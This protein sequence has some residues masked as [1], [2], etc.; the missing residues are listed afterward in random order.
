MYE[1]NL[2]FYYSAVFFFFFFLSTIYLKIEKWYFTVIHS[3]VALQ[4]SVLGRPTDK[5]D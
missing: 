2:R 5:Y 1:L 4:S 3:L